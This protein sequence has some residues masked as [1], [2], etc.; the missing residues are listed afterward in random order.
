[1][2]VTQNWEE[3]LCCASCHGPIG[4]GEE[5]LYGKHLPCV[6]ADAAVHRRAGDADA[7]TAARRQLD[8]PGH[9]TLTRGQLRELILQATAAGIAPVHRPDRGRRCKWY[10]RM[11]GWSEERVS[12]ELSVDEVAGL[13]EDFLAAGRTPPLKHGDLAK[14][15]DAV[16][17]TRKT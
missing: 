16:A 17:A 3:G 8:R 7:L 15:L 5:M 2:A 13:W 11:P 4:L 9:I 14:V 6:R 10:S 12:G 1:M